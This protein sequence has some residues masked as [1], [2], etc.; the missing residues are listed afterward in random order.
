MAARSCGD[1]FGHGPSSKALRAAAHAAS[2]S[3]GAASG[4][5]PTSSPVAG[6]CTSMTSAVDGSTH[7]P[8]MNNLSQCVLN[9][10]LCV[11]SV[12]LPIGWSN[13][14]LL[15]FAVSGRPQHQHQIAHCELP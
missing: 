7:L 5:L 1:I 6:E 11:M 8:P 14:N 4:T 3:A 2:T 12:T 15:Q 10:V 13:E 9:A